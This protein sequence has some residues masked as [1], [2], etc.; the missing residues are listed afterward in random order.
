MNRRLVFTAFRRPQYFATVLDHWSRVRGFADWKPTVHL[1]PSRV[2]HQMTTLALDAGVAVCHND[3][4][5]GVAGNPFHALDSAFTD[6]AD[7]VVLAE[8]DEVVSTDALEFFTWASDTFAD[9]NVLTVCAASLAPHST[10]E[11]EHHVTLSGTFC[12]QLWGT[13][14]DRWHDIIRPTW[15]HNYSTRSPGGP[16]HETGWDWNLYRRLVPG[17][18][19]VHPVASRSNHIGRIDGVH[20]TEANFAGTQLLTYIHH[21]PP[22]IYTV[23]PLKDGNAPTP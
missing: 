4:R 16:A 20:T 3:V 10:P 1:E 14:A 2:I 6:G 7:F 11:E 19:V 8:D 9:S 21:R 17:R 18:R 12:S 15:D 23:A 22:G 13:W 5:L